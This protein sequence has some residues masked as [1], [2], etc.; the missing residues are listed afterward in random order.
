MYKIHKNFKKKGFDFY[1]KNINSVKKTILYRIALPILFM[2]LYLG[3]PVCSLAAQ[4]TTEIVANAEWMIHPVGKGVVIKKCHFDNLLGGPQDVCVTDADFSTSGVALRFVGA[5]GIRKPVSAFSQEAPD[6][7]AAINGNWFDYKTN[8]PIQ[9]T[10][11]DGMIRCPTIPEAQERGGIVIDKYGAVSC[12]TCPE[13]GWD[14]VKEDN[15]MASEIPL[16]VNGQP[17]T[18][19]PAGAPDYD[20]YYVNRHPRSS[21]GVTA[22][23]HVIFVVVDGRRPDSVGASYSHM[24]E[25]LSALGAVNATTLDGG[26]S[27]TCWGSGYGVLNKPSGGQERL[28]ADALVIT[29]PPD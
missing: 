26:G 20:Y 3:F 15:V 7:A 21:I 14:S 6:A 24:A 5:A 29:A 8:M 9:F 22:D 17:Y 12:R 1:M 2:A 18:W 25:L 10:K 27:S 19:T 16:L 4:T 28:V 23:N 13:S 11:I